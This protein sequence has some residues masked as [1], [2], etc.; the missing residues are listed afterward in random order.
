[1]NI[2]LILGDGRFLRQG[3]KV[4]IIKKNANVNILRSKTSV[5]PKYLK[6]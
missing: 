2:F 1:M 3:A 6:K 4:F 5:H